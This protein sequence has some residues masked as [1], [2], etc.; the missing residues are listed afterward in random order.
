VQSIGNR[1]GKDAYPTQFLNAVDMVLLHEG[2]YSCNPA[3]RGGSTKF[4]ISAREYP[5]LDIPNLTR[6]D[7]V[8]IYW[9]D[10]WLKFRF[11]HLP[12]FVSGKTF[13]LSVNIGGAQAVRC[14]QR[15]LR[16][17]GELVE[18]DGVVGPELVGACTRAN[19]VALIPALR[20]EAAG[21]YRSIAAL[22]RGSRAD[23]DREFLEGWLNR[24][25]E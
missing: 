19:P 12:A 1:D 25:Y 11:D 21:Y 24:A 22:S 17:C 23:G 14:L 8:R 18:E 15:A 13:D 2:G 16:S 5:K 6:D 10:W 9:R 20:S 3:D 4:G 7:A